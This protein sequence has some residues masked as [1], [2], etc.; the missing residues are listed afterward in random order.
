MYDSLRYIR[1]AHIYL[2]LFH[3]MT[4]SYLIN[5]LPK[6]HKHTQVHTCSIQEL[7]SLY[8]LILSRNASYAH[9]PTCT[10]FKYH[11]SGLFK[12]RK[13]KNFLLKWKC[14]TCQP[15]SSIF[16]W[17]IFHPRYGFKLL[18]TN[19]IFYLFFFTYSLNF[20]IIRNILNFKTLE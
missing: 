17:L 3:M 13:R 1:S 12:L 11:V 16:F 10:C 8:V 7:F 9:R 15:I 19:N 18:A 6:K 2:M 20:L 5:G 14:V 4:S